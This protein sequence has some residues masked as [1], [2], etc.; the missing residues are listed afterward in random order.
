METTLARIWA[1]VLKLD[2][3]G[4]HDN[5]F[6][7]GGH[8]LLAVKMISM[9]RQIGMVTTVADI[10]NHPTI[11]SFAASLLSTSVSAS[12]R[13]ARQ[14]REGTQTP[15]FL[16]HD[17]YGDELYFYA[18]AQHLPTEL[19]IYGLPCVP[20]NEP[21]LYTLQTMAKRMVTLV[22]EVQAQG[23]YR[24]AGWSLAASWHTK[25]YSNCWIRDTAWNSWV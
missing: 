20:E 6:E 2:R 18:L 7:V 21:Q 4:R 12:R 25:S 1:E 8:S 15:L 14:I 23:P 22:Q 13:G 5:F 3:M 11:E 17:G 24:L 16:V 10:F 19:P 9:L